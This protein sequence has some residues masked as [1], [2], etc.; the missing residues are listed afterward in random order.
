MT[1]I[2]GGYGSAPGASAY[3]GLGFDPLPGDPA[4]AERLAADARRIGARLDDAAIRLGRLAAPYGWHGEAAEA[5]TASLRTLPRDLVISAQ[6]CLRLAAELDRYR[7]AYVDALARARRLDAQAT[8]VRDRLASARAAAESWRGPRP[9]VGAY[10]AGPTPGDAAVTAAEHEL[11]TIQRAARNLRADLEDATRPV[12]RAIHELTEHA[13][14]EPAWHELKRLARALLPATPIGLGVAA[15]DRVVGAYPEVSDDLADVLGTVSAALGMAATLTFWIPGVGQTLGV[16]A[17]VTS[18][19]ATLI[20]ASLYL[21]EARDQNGKRYVTGADLAG[22][23]AGTAVGMVA[24]AASIAV[25]VRSGARLGPAIASQLAVAG[26]GR[27]GDEI[28]A[29]ANLV[30]RRGLLGG[31]IH[32]SRTESVVWRAMGAAQRSTYLIS[33]GSDGLG[34]QSGFGVGRLPNQVVRLVTDEPDTPDLRVG[35]QPQLRAAR[36]P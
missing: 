35:R 12:V 15:V 23:G 6:S 9:V 31:A 17:L 2:I 22:S 26:P 33:R 18:G 28:M 24:P 8:E 16:F 27:F 10:P 32:I 4:L 14:A 1:G 34:L 11:V 36:R 29:V 20:K 13:P 21:H 7:H 30:R 25:A 3:P 19:G 5:F